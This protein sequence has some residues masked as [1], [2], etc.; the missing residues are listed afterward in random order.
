MIK[1]TVHL[2]LYLADF[3]VPC[4]LCV[5]DVKIEINITLEKAFYASLQSLFLVCHY[6]HSLS[7]LCHPLSLLL[8]FLQ[9]SLRSLHTI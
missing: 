7:F 3:T 5:R 2:L 9:S 8:F 6:S 1:Q 4:I